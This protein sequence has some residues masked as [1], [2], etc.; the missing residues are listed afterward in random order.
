[1][2]P[3]SVSSLPDGFSEASEA[4]ES[5]VFEPDSVAA[6]VEPVVDDRETGDLV[7]TSILTVVAPE[8]AQDGLEKVSSATAGVLPESS[9]A[10]VVEET[11]R[12]GFTMRPETIS[13]K[14][15]KRDKS[16]KRAA[17]QAKRARVEKGPEDRIGGLWALGI[18]IIGIVLAFL[19]VVP[20][21]GLFMG[22]LGVVWGIAGL[23]VNRAAKKRFAWIGLVASFLSLV[24]Y[25]SFNIGAVQNAA[26]A[27]N[28]SVGLE[29]TA[30]KKTYKLHETIKLSSGLNVTVTSNSFGVKGESDKPATGKS[31]VLVD[32]RLQN[33]SGKKMTVNKDSFKLVDAGKTYDFD[34]QL[35]QNVKLD[36]TKFDPLLSQ[37]LGSGQAVSGTLVG[38]ATPDHELKL[39]GV[40]ASGKTIFTVKLSK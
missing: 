21:G 31:F 37:D 25:F 38:E 8:E 7:A 13:A 30:K 15:A 34:T 6:V 33:T 24:V 14:S 9:A 28:A 40:N 18:G 32:L 3:T 23:I 29:A 5:A 22:V 2:A 35:K 12:D 20:R 36:G 1:M 19:P 39:I 16:G 10:N 27:G 4:V 17:K 11:T 26:N